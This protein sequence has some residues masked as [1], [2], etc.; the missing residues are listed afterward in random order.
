[1]QRPFYVLFLFLFIPSLSFSSPLQLADEDPNQEKY[2]I[3]EK[4]FDFPICGPTPEE[5][6]KTTLVEIL[7]LMAEIK[8][9]VALQAP[10]EE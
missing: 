2:Y 9:R 7:K 1:M 6:Q 8:A 4:L 10:E 5:A 3:P